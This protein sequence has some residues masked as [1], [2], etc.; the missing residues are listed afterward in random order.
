M[1]ACTAEP[2]HQSRLLVDTVV[3]EKSDQMGLRTVD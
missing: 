3:I 1:G 2:E